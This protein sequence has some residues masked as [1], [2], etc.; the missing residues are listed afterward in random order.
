MGISL[1]PGCTHSN[2]ANKEGLSKEWEGPESQ[3]KRILRVEACKENR[4]EDLPTSPN[5]Q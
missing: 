3:G 4:A 5:G 2:N 1:H